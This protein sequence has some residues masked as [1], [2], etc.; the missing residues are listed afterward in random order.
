MK[1]NYLDNKGNLQNITIECENC[2]SLEFRD[3]S[4]FR[5]GILRNDYECASCG[6]KHS[7]PK[8]WVIQSYK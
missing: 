5:P 1:F 3:S 7:F 4:D 2:K 8:G 6:Q